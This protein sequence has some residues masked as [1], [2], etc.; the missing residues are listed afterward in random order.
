MATR[1]LWV[2]PFASTCIIFAMLVAVGV[3]NSA[4]PLIHSSMPTPSP[5]AGAGDGGSAA[6]EFSPP[7]L[8]TALFASLA[9]L[10]P[11]CVSLLR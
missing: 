4:W 2:G 7:F 10:L 5:H 6:A 8:M 9:F 11:F 3:S 1:M